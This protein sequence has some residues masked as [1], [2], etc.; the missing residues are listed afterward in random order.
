LARGNIA[1]RLPV[2]WKKH[3]KKVKENEDKKKEKE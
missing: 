3:E 1:A 2:H